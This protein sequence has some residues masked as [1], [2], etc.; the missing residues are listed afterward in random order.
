[1]ARI[2]WP[3][4]EAARLCHTYCTSRNPSSQLASNYA[5][6]F[7]M[8]RKG[9]FVVRFYLW[10]HVLYLFHSTCGRI[11]NR[12]AL[13]SSVQM[14]L[15]EDKWIS[16]PISSHLHILRIVSTGFEFTFNLIHVLS[17]SWARWFNFRTRTTV[18]SRTCTGGR[19]VFL[20]LLS[21]CCVCT[22][23]SFWIFLAQGT[24]RRAR[25]NC[26]LRHYLNISSETLKNSRINLE[27]HLREWV[28]RR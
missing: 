10:L 16:E 24:Q 18:A 6:S 26:D 5:L 27:R 22:F 7:E 1:M 19:V 28:F 11:Q 15:N 21:L 9:Y 14:I 8:Q 13:P 25:R 12:W 2:I 17:Y 4:V 23:I 3:D 20:L